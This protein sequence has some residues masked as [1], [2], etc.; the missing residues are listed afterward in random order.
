MKGA[1]PADMSPAHCAAAGGNTKTSTKVFLL[2]LHSRYKSLPTHSE[3]FLFPVLI[4]GLKP[5]LLPQARTPPPCPEYSFSFPFFFGESSSQPM[6]K[7][8]AHITGNSPG[9]RPPKTGAQP[10]HRGW[11]G[12]KMLPSAW[13]QSSFP[14]APLQ[15]SSAAVN[16]RGGVV[17]TCPVLGHAGFWP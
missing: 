12:R 6:M 16:L 15:P 4:T 13:E 1:P 8:L 7:G 5:G 10:R 2:V 11:A 9:L 3:N 14:R 17:P